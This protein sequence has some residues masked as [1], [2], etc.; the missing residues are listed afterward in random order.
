MA[1]VDRKV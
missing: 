1:N